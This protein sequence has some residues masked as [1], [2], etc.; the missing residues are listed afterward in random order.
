MSLP[1]VIQQRLD[2]HISYGFELGMEFLTTVD[3]LQSGREVRN[4]EWVRGQHL[5]ECT[6][7]LTPAEY[8][9]IIKPMH[10][11][12]RGARIAFR[13]KDWSDYQLTNAPLGNAA[14]GAQV[15]QLTRTLTWGGVDYQDIIEAPV[16]GTI[17]LSAAG[18]PIAS[19]VDLVTGEISF[20]ATAGQALTVTGEFDRWVRFEDD[21]LPASW[22]N[23]NRIRVPIRLRED[24]R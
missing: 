18:V 1:A 2:P 22:E 12:T 7:I 3:Q 24:F 17:V 14:G 11:A 16:S 20:T 23:Y 13:F 21:R 15:L 6:K 8:R 10:A 9:T 19:T 5:Y 4:S